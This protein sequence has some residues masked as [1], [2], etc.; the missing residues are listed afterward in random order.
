MAFGI[1]PAQPAPKSVY[2]SITVSLSSPESILERSF[3]EVLKPG[4]IL[5]VAAG[6]QLA[7]ITGAIEYGLQ[8]IAD[9]RSPFVHLAQALEQG[10][11]SLDAGD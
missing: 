7:D 8:Q 1:K 11:E 2:N 10:G 9:A 5:R 3:G 6:L 4:L